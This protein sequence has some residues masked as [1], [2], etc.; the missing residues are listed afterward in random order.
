MERLNNFV[1]NLVTEFYNVISKQKVLIFVNCDI[2]AICAAKILQ[3][4]F[5]H[6]AV[7]YTLIPVCTISELRDTYNE[8]IYDSKNVIMINC[9]GTIDI[10][11]VLQPERDVTFFI[12][13]SHKPTDLYNIYINNQV[14]LLCKPDPEEGIPDYFEIF[15]E[16]ENNEDDDSND[17]DE[18]ISDDDDDEY[19]EN[20]AAKRA[21]LDEQTLQ[22]RRER[23][24]WED[25]RQRIMFEYVQF[26][27]YGRSSAITM[28]ELAWRLHRDNVDLLWWGI[29]GVVEQF[30]LNK[31]EIV[32]YL[33]EVEK[34]SAHIGRLCQD[35]SSV[36]SQYSLSSS[37]Q[38]NV[39]S[40][41]LRID[42]EKDLQLALYRHWTVE[43]SLKYTM[44]TAVALQLWAI[45]GEKRIQKLL[46]EM[47]LPLAESRQ[48][49]SSMDLALRK[50]FHS[51]MEKMSDS[52]NLTHITYPS[53]TLVHGFR[54]K[55]QA[56]D[57]VYSLL[58]L[59]SNTT[60]GKTFRDCF[61]DALDAL[62]R[63][64]KELLD[65]GIEK[66][67]KFLVC[68]FKHVQSALDMRQ[69]ISAGPFFYFVIQEDTTNAK[70]YSNP[71]CLWL[72]AIFTLRAYVAA[73]RKSKAARLPLLASAPLEEGY[74]LIVGV[75]PVA[76]TAPRSFFGQ[77]FEQ[78]AE[79]TNCSIFNHYFDST[80]TYI[81][82]L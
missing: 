82:N 80:G 31:V 42:C 81:N 66:S 64:K 55:Y 57:Y 65:D 76:E 72:L 68:M 20:Q 73:S 18:N 47:G 63:T 53:F 32:P 37:S 69:V 44:F 27:Y 29:I 11:E 24:I 45:K 33:S 14:R 2:D 16:D 40:P 17:I 25:N 5:K 71:D 9:G 6:D 62:S 49:Y 26:S 59:L 8:H 56:A 79:R 43:S 10:I 61:F 7:A 13:D 28:Y 58:A 21:R 36:A 30:I 15:H 51:M 54:T 70:Y 4:I 50:E 38:T 77:A 74:C 12:A 75:P 3:T 19:S 46:A 35:T 67:K 39:T 41:S 1:E 78:A 23:R 34:I 52:R 60:R 48:Q 22:K